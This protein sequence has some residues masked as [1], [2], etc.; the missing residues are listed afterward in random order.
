MRFLYWT[1]RVRKALFGGKDYLYIGDSIY[2]KSPLHEDQRDERS[3]KKIK[4]EVIPKG[5]AG[6]IVS[7][8]GKRDLEF[9]YDFLKNGKGSIELMDVEIQYTDLI[10]NEVH[11]REVPILSEQGQKDF[12]E[13]HS[14]LKKVSKY[15]QTIGK[16][17]GSLWRKFS[18]IKKC[19][20]EFEYD[21]CVSVHTSQ[22]RSFYFSM[23]DISDIRKALTVNRNADL[24][25]SLGYVALTRC[26]IGNFVI[27]MPKKK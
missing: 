3:G 9:S 17:T 5:T 13:L 21:Y 27:F 12:K 25:R 24:F 20:L 18:R 16:N 7:I 15:Y 26:I 19:F 23:I 6:R 2:A 8:G 10:T 4:V 11:I 1:E 22:G 14:A